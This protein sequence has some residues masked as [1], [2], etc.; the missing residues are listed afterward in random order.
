MEIIYIYTHTHKLRKKSWQN[1]DLG[2]SNNLQFLKKVEFFPGFQTPLT[3]PFEPDLFQA[4]VNTPGM[5][6]KVFTF[7]ASFEGVFKTLKGARRYADHSTKFMINLAKAADPFSEK[8]VRA[9]KSH[10]SSVQ[11]GLFMEGFFPGKCSF[12]I[13]HL[14]V[15]CT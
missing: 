1:Q 15:C 9:G 6:G 3:S 14:K 12:Y 7:K 5:Q 10:F 11:L 13:G 8:V 4:I 2:N